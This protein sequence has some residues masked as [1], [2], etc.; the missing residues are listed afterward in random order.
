MPWRQLAVHQR[1]LELVLEVRDRAQAAD[2]ARCALL[3][4]RVVDQQAV[5]GLDLDVGAALEHLADDRDALVALNSGVFSTLTSTATMIR[6]KIARAALDDVD[7]AVGQRIERPG[8]DRD[9][10]RMRV[11]SCVERSARC[12]PSVTVRV[13]VQAVRL[14]RRSRATACSRISSPSGG[15]LRRGVVRP[16]RPAARNRTADRAPRCRTVR[17]EAASQRALARRRG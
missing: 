14:R 12:R 13:S 5:E 8:I 1:H 11:C 9:A 10:R 4:L 2:D 16:P 15:A 6:S 3:P 7:V 17:R